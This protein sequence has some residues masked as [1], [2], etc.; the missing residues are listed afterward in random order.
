[1]DY[2]QEKNGA[3]SG[4]GVTAN[5][6]VGPG[7]DNLVSRQTSTGNQSML[8]DALGSVIKVTDAN[9]DTVASYT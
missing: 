9:Q 6:I 8:K 2:V 7:I 5:L 4:A 3:G 1:M